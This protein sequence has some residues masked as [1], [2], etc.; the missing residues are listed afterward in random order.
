[1][2]YGARPRQGIGAPSVSRLIM[3]LGAQFSGLSGS[4]CIGGDGIT[5]HRDVTAWRFDGDMRFATNVGPRKPPWEPN[6][7]SFLFGFKPY[8]EPVSIGKV[9]FPFAGVG[10][11]P[12]TFV[13][14]GATFVAPDPWLFCVARY[15][16]G[17]VCRVF[18]WHGVVLVH[19]LPSVP[20]VEVYNL[21]WCVGNSS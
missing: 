3:L 20:V 14:V 5:I 9:A 11:V 8:G 18:W 19:S 12:D 13:G 1:M 10:K 6:D 4:T 2:V 16:Y 21:Q 7:S 15:P 17:V